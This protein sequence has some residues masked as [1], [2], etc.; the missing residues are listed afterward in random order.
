[1]FERQR[2]NSFV[3]RL[4]EP[5]RYIQILAG[6]R[7]VGKTTLVHQALKHLGG[8]SVFASADLPQSQQAGWLRQQWELGRMEVRRHGAPCLL[9]IDEI[10]K[11]PDWSSYVK[12]LWDEDTKNG[13]QL[14]VLLLGSAPLLL[15][16][17]LS[18]SLTGRF[19]VFRLYHWSFAEMKAAFGLSLDEYIFYGGYPGAAPLINDYPR[20]QQYVHDSLIETT[21]TKDI[22][23]ITRIDKPALMRRLFGFG[24]IYSG[25]IFSYQKMLGQLHDVGNVTTL[26]HYLDLLAS[27]GLL[28]GLQKYSGNTIKLRGSSPKLQVFNSAL[29]N[30]QLSV[31][32]ESARAQPD[33]W[34]RLVESAVGAYLLNEIQGTSIELYY[35]RDRN[36][37]VDYVLKQGKTLVAIEVKSGRLRGELSGMNDFIKR[38]KPDKTILVGQDGITLEQ[39]FLTPLTTLIDQKNRPA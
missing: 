16:R 14:K 31:T 22:L 28:A 9:V 19:E 39:F 13:V 3:A 20:W 17:G 34:G 26:S 6:P 30:A 38:F 10:Q 24:S 35:W 29:T 37:E 25:Q 32:F 8:P 7:Q 18:E 15:Q 33:Q 2:L 1:M 4:S 36:Q 21:I 11:V 5:R 12:S 23:Q 27:A